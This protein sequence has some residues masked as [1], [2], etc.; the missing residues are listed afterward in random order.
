MFRW[1]SYATEVQLISVAVCS[2]VSQCEC[3]CC[4]AYVVSERSYLQVPPKAESTAS[5]PATEK[6]NRRETRET[7]ETPPS[8]LRV[9]YRPHSLC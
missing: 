1:L 8:R 5:S 2:S 4:S 6:A 9:T 3:E 7:Q